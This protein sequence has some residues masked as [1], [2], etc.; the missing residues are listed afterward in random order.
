MSL[1]VA[2]GIG[3]VAAMIAAHGINHVLHARRHG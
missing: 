3:I 1:V 2:L